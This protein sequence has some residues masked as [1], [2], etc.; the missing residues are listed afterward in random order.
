MITLES[1]ITL[2]SVISPNGVISDEDGDSDL[3]AALKGHLSQRFPS[4]NAY[5]K[6]GICGNL[7]CFPP[8]S[9]AR[10]KKVRSDRPIDSEIDGT[11]P[12]L[13]PLM[14]NPPIG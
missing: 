13:A 2:C 11:L 6:K 14:G 3:G 5:G 9:R 7:L 8:L 12:S 4:R 10:P 1:V